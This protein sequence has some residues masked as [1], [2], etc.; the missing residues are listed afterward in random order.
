MV[1]G[2]QPQAPPVDRRHLID[3]LLSLES[4]E[5]RQPALMIIELS[6]L[7]TINR[8]F[9]YEAGEHALAELYQRLVDAMKGEEGIF[10]I[11]GNQFAVVTPPLP[12]FGFAVV[13]ATRL[14]AR[15]SKDVSLEHQHRDIRPEIN[16]GI[17]LLDQYISVNA[18]WAVI[19]EAEQS[20][21]LD[22]KGIAFH[23]HEQ[24]RGSALSADLNELANAFRRTLQENEFELYYQPKLHLPTGEVQRAE[25]LLRWQ[26]PEL[27]FIS[28][29]RV[30]RIAEQSGTLFELSKWVVFRAVRQIREWLDEGIKMCVAVNLP[31]DL[32]PDPKIVEMV[33]NALAIW[34]VPG[35]QLTIEITES[36]IMEDKRSGHNNLLSLRALGCRVSIDDFGTGFSSLSYFKDIPATEL[37][38]DKSFVFNMRSEKQDR[39]IVELILQIAALFDFSV[40]A[41]GI[42]DEETLHMLAELGCDYAQGYHIARPMP[43]NALPGWLNHFHTTEQR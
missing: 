39:D 19:V 18:C 27:G 42:E 40:V 35:E 21:E 5:A 7:R 11:N 8:S 41:E 34:D 22:A 10:R 17:T 25:A 15:L 28:P 14:K 31:A 2:E 3:T 29:M 13:I 6:N 36:A 12:N 24:N 9:D 26:L 4:S 43:A 37:K 1:P 30:M 23:Q 33:K 20:L 32:A 38:I 16:L